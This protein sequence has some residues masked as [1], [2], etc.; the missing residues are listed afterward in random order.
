[1]PSKSSDFQINNRTYGTETKPIIFE[2]RPVEPK[3]KI[4]YKTLK[5]FM[6]PLKLQFSTPKTILIRGYSTI[7][8]CDVAL[9]PIKFQKSVISNFTG[10][11]F[12]FLQAEKEARSNR[13]SIPGTKA[14]KLIAL[15]P[16][17]WEEIWKL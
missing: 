8:I 10:K 6:F 16:F 4:L 3:K 11:N 9:R 2:Q 7:K 1:M 5:T 14:V 17:K 15:P 13:D 12:N